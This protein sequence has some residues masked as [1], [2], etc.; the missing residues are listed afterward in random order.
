MYRNEGDIRPLHIGSTYDDKIKEKL[1][2]KYDA[3]FEYDR[4]AFPNVVKYSE[5]IIL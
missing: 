4:F 3:F 5:E 2:T 1:L